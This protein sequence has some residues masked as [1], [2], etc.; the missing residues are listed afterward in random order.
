MV[1]VGP[2]CHLPCAMSSVRDLEYLRRHQ[3]GT[4]YIFMYTSIHRDLIYIFMYISTYIYIYVYQD[5]TMWERC[6]GWSALSSAMRH[7]STGL[8][9]YGTLYHY[10]YNYMYVRHVRTAHV[11]HTLFQYRTCHVALPLAVAVPHI[12]TH[13]V[14]TGP[15]RILP[16]PICLHIH[17]YGTMHTH[18]YIIIFINTAHH[19]TLVRGRA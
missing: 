4:L 5:G 3:Y 12:R 14:I 18:T 8:W 2:L 19:A 17:L 1:A 11:C 9:Q 10:T 16:I 6:S 13:C 7:F 15:C